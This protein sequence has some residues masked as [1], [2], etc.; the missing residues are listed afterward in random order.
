MSKLQSYPSDNE[1]EIEELDLPNVNNRFQQRLLQAQQIANEKEIEKEL[2]E[3]KNQQVPLKNKDL[4]KEYQSL[5]KELKKIEQEI[6]HMNLDLSHWKEK[7]RKQASLMN[8]TPNVRAEMVTL[9]DNDRVTKQ[10]LDSIFDYFFELALTPLPTNAV[11]M[12]IPKFVDN[13]KEMK[14]DALKSKESRQQS[15]F[16][17]IKFT[18]METWY[19]EDVIDFDLATRHSRLVGRAYETSFKIT[20]DITPN[21]DIVNLDFE[22][23]LD[24]SLDAKDVLQGIKIDGNLLMLFRLLKHFGRLK[25]DMHKTFDLLESQY[26]STEILVTRE[27]DNSLMFTGPIYDDPKLTLSW[28]YETTSNYHNED[29]DINICEQVIPVV[30]LNAEAPWKSEK[31]YNLLSQV[32]EKFKK[33]LSEQGVIIATQIMIGG[34]LIEPM[35]KRSEGIV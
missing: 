9:E 1:N 16:T 10:D 35:L 17:H 26:Q 18:E 27:G 14:E 33:L 28:K 31:L 29:M 23:D 13:Y 24:L 3:F 20:Y 19:D 32:P 22:V 34:I 15:N 4:T 21:L 8:L 7:R 11:D 2:T 30:E 25:Y 6:D 12:D 5:K